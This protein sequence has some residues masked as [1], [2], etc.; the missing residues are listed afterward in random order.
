MVCSVSTAK[1]FDRRQRQWFYKQHFANARG[2]QTGASFL[3][4]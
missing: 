1:M 2:R 3:S 4:R